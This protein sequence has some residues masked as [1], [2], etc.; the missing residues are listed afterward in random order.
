VYPT[1]NDGVELNYL[2]THVTKTGMFFPIIAEA[3][4]EKSW[5]VFYCPKKSQQWLNKSNL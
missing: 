1:L 5:R 2:L 3:R 4:P